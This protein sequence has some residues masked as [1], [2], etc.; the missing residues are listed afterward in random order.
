VTR[1]L[2]VALC[3]LSSGCLD[4]VGTAFPDGGSEAG[5]S[6][7]GGLAAGGSA[8][9][10][11]A[12]GGS[13]AGGLAAGGSA[14]GGLAAG[15]SAAGGLAAG[16]SAAGGSTAGGS[17]AGG[18]TAGGSTAGGSAAGGSAAGG[19][20]AG[21]SAAGGSAAGGSAAGGS[22]AGGSAA[23][24][25]AGGSALVCPGPYHLCGA[26]CVY[27]VSPDH[28]GL[29]CS[30][31]PGTDGGVSTCTTTGQCDIFCTPPNQKFQ[32][33]GGSI[34]LAPTNWTEVFASVRPAARTGHGLAWSPSRQAAMLF[35]GETALPAQFNDLWSFRNGGWEL[36]DA[37][38]APSPRSWA[39]IAWDEPRA[40]LVAFGGVT[41]ASPNA[42][43]WIFDGASWSRRAFDG[44][45]PTP[46]WGAAMA[47]DSDSQTI[48]MFGGTF[49][50]RSSTTRTD[51]F[52]E[53]NGSSWTQRPK[54]APWPPAI[55]EASLV[56]A[57]GRL[58]LS[59]CLEGTIPNSDLWEWNNGVWRLLSATGPF[60][61]SPTAA[62]NPARNLLVVFGFRTYPTTSIETW[63]W[64]GVWRQR[65][66][67]NQ[68]SRRSGTSMVW[69]P[70]RGAGLL[71]GGLSSPSSLN[72]VLNDSW[73]YQ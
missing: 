26:D 23:G 38:V 20:A 50:G 3:S 73:E 60:L 10:G 31:C 29:R 19:S 22:A 12:A 42:E 11:L 6:A 64:D 4:V 72:T 5:G 49:G 9:G 69:V 70:A 13:A 58:L 57:D 63:E 24:G 47:F 7:A 52:W 15:G 18:S 40:Q 65:M 68:P 53:W 46:R 17:A 36:V 67:V 37:G 62:W 41:S 14:A 54:R 35:G 61:D 39:A 28:C 21:G 43:T 27:N 55:A 51:E 16:G 33:D 71:F 34:C 66:P 44:G 56:Q 30:P 2:V 59:G 45:T 1:Y 32:V 25:S 48:A 8:A